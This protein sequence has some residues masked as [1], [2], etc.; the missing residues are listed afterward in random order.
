MNH[1]CNMST[2]L[3][4]QSGSIY[5]YMPP[6][7]SYKT[8]THP[9][10]PY[11][12]CTELGVIYTAEVG[13]LAVICIFH[14]LSSID[15]ILIPPSKNHS[16]I[17]INRALI[18]YPLVSDALSFTIPC[19]LYPNALGKSPVT[20]TSFTLLLPNSFGKVSGAQN[21]LHIITAKQ[22]WESLR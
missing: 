10:P 13:G 19:H 18:P 21:K 6:P 1:V 7:P 9:H 2:E 4:F 22:L 15:S 5:V 11:T 16:R 12:G 17:A 14:G 8:P 20:R 3:H